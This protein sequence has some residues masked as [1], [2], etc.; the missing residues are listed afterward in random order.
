[1]LKSQKHIMITCS[2]VA[3]LSYKLANYIALCIL[4][5]CLSLHIFISTFNI[6]NGLFPKL[7]NDLSLSSL[8]LITPRTV[9]NYT[10]LLLL[11][12]RKKNT[13]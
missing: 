12:A 4:P 11:I 5:T 13:D 2:K 10:L 1:M 3:L 8:Y 7:F 9:Y 6:Y